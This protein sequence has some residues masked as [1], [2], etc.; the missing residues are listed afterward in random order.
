MDSKTNFT[1]VLPYDKT[2]PISIF[3]Y[4]KGLLGKTLR[5]FVY[6]GYQPHEGKG[7]LG[8]MVENLYFMLETNNCPEADFSS[9][10]MEL[11][12][13]PLKKSK[14]DDYLIK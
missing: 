11:K 5:E 12:C 1:K 7:S 14:N 13:T 4:S 2:S 6:E 9:A 8:Q 3:D 10:G